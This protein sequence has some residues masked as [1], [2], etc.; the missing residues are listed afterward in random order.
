MRVLSLL[1]PGGGHSGVLRERAAAGGHELV[2]WVPGSGQDAPGPLH[3]FDAVAVFGGGMNVADEE[4]LPWLTGEVELLREALA[5]GMPALGVCLGAQL[6]ARA[7]GARVHR[8]AAPEIGWL[9]VEREPA[10]E[11]D[12]L[13]GDLPWS[14]LAYQWHSYAFDL[15]PGAVS[16]A[17]SDVCVQ[18]FALNGTAWGVQF[19]PEVTPDIVRGWSEDYESDP[20]AVALGFDP[21]AALAEAEL[22]LPEWN[23]IGRTL[24]D[25]W[26]SRAASAVPEEAAAPAAAAPPPPRG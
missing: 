17:R 24:F 19:H 14:F 2:E 8:A 1:H 9:T 12:P 21:A 15:P 11:G 20:D 23:A 22:R 25:G 5:R 4:R 13:L 7:G 26:L 6:L 16:L 18:A 10:S 3:T